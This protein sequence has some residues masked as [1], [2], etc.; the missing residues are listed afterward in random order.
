MSQ[1]LLPSTT[2]IRI[3]EPQVIIT[4]QERKHRKQI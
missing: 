4:N 3:T 2:Q 1:P